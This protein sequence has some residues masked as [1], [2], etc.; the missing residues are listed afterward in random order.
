MKKWIE[1]RNFFCVFDSISDMTKYCKNTP[2]HPSFYAR[3][4]KENDYSFTH[5]KSFEEAEELISRGWEEGY[6]KLTDNLKDREV[7]EEIQNK[8]YVPKTDVEGFAPCVPHVIIGRPDTMVNA[9]FH[10]KKFKIVDI[11][12][13]IGV[14]GGTSTEDIINRGI[15]VLNYISQ[16][17]S[18]GYRCNLYVARC[19]IES[20]ESVFF[21]TKV[22]ESSEPLSIKRLAFPLIHPSMNRRFMFR[23]L[24]TLPVCNEWCYGYGRTTDVNDKVL[25]KLYRKSFIFPSLNTISYCEPITYIKKVKKWNNDTNTTTD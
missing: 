6:K 8:R 14:N 15:V 22:K 7:D 13:N 10:P 21:L 9:E 23:I 20:G 16:L 5:T 24:E 12:V 17:E 19:G 25:Y 3:S 2:N 4:S 11:I 1:G 18:A